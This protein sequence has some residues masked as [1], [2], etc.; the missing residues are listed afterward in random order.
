MATR[1]PRLERYVPYILIAPSLAYI[2]FFIG[3]PLAQALHLAFT[4][5]GAFSLKNIDYLL[6]SPFSKFTEALVN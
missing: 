5:H 6:H 3:Y 1:P 2:L 4:E